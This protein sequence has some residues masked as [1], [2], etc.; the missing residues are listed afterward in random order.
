MLIIYFKRNTSKNKG[1]M[2][3]GL[4]FDHP[5]GEVKEIDKCY[6]PC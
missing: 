5:V 4:W 1:L 2:I 6:F 3:D